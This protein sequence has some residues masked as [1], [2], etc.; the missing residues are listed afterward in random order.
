MT[1]M[2]KQILLPSLLT[3]LLFQSC[4][5][6]AP[7]AGADK[8]AN[9]WDA[10]YECIR[11]A[12]EGKSCGGQFKSHTYTAKVSTIQKDELG[13]TQLISRFGSGDKAFI[14][15][16]PNDKTDQFAVGDII[17]FEGTVT[18]ITAKPM[19]RAIEFDNCNL[20]KSGTL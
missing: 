4:A 11:T 12:P 3:F 5:T 6:K 20:R 7:F 1:H 15:E 2:K 18:G 17:Q 16:L 10:I 13:H 9:T 19:Q 14:C 8:T